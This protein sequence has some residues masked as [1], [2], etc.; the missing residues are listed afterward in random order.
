M[1]LKV[2]DVKGKEVATLV[3]ERLQPGTYSTQ[4]NASAYTSGVYFY[5][6]TADG[7]SETKRMVLL[8]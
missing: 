1:V 6:L 2:Y 8:K 7:Y 4:W 5:R 3:N